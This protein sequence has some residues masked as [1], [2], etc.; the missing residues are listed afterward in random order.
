VHIFLS[1][2]QGKGKI[3][4]EIRIWAK[5]FEKSLFSGSNRP[6]CDFDHFDQPH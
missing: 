6:L 4:R 1:A 5:K 2:I 3:A